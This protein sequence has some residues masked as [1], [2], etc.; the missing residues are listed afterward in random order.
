MV[1]TLNKK[2]VTKI[3]KQC[4]LV[5]RAICL[6]FIPKSIE[7]VETLFVAPLSEMEQDEL[8]LAEQYANLWEKS[9]ELLP[10]FCHLF[11]TFINVN[12]HHDHIIAVKHASLVL[13]ALGFI[14]MVS[15]TEMLKACQYSVLDK[16][17]AFVKFIN[18]DIK[19]TQ[20]AFPLLCV[21]FYNKK[22]RNTLCTSYA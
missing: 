19:N 14:A 7:S 1:N 4:L 11:R 8:N 9:A 17:T 10:A 22:K 5:L 15:F 16:A 21:F 20:Q 13:N 6:F 2:L 12:P 3:F 18:K